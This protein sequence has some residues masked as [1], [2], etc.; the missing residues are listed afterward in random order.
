MAGQ[1]CIQCS[2]RW[3]RP[4]RRK[5]VRK[6]VREGQETGSRRHLAGGRR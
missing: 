1:S 2:R 5:E 4:G 6:V 3:G